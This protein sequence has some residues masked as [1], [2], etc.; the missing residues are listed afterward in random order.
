MA[1]HLEHLRRLKEEGTVQFVGRAEETDGQESYGFVLIEA[2]DAAHAL[3]IA[4]SDPAVAE[5]L[6]RLELQPFTIVFDGAAVTEEVE[7]EMEPS[8]RRG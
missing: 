2:K 3:S 6:M 7:P 1:R 8:Q 4:R 5:G